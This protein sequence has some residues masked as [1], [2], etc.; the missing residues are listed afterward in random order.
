MNPMIDAAKEY[1]SKKIALMKLEATEK[2]SISAG[3]ITFV[4]LVS[5]AFLFFIIMLNIGLG[6][7]IG[8][9]I[10]NYAYGILIIAGFYLLIL[11]ILFIA[12]KSITYGIANKIIKALNN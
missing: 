1:A 5:I 7:L 2:S 8:S 9:L 3:T 6:L 12:R 11:F 10:G 4:V